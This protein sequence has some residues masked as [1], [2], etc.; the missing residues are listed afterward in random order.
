ML[1]NIL[2]SAVVLVN[3][4]KNFLMTTRP[5]GKKMSG[6]WEFPGGKVEFGAN[7]YQTAVR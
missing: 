3:T 4:E 6:F 5:L 7:F 2:V 1:N